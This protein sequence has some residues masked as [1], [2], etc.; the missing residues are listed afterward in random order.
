MARGPFPSD[1]RPDTNLANL[2]WEHHHRRA[3]SQDWT[4]SGKAHAELTFV[5]PTGRA[6]T[7][8]PTPLWTAVIASARPPVS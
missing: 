7:S 6:M 8:V 2:L 1:G 5:G 4:M 3:H